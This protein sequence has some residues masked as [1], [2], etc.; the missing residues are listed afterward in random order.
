MSEKLPTRLDEATLERTPREYQEQMVAGQELQ[1]QD[2][3]DPERGPIVRA[4][5]VATI[6]ASKRV[7]EKDSPYNELEV[8]RNAFMEHFGSQEARRYRL[9]HIII[10]S[11]PPSTSD[12]FDADGEWS[13]ATKMQELSEKYGMGEVDAEAA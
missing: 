9:F 13:I 5:R 12:L 2:R 4:V 1:R 7:A 6:E 10:G 8:F 11:T 3:E